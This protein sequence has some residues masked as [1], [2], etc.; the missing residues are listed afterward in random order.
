MNTYFRILKF[1]KP[2]WKHLSLSIFSTLFFSLLSGASIYLTIPLLSTLFQESKK[3]VVDTGIAGKAS[4]L[5]PGWI[6]QRM[7]DISN[8][9]N[10]FVFTGSTSDVLLKI[11]V[12]I[13]ITFL[14]KNVFGYLQAYFLAYV[15]QGVI[16]DLR[17]ST[18]RHLHKLPM[19]YF[20][21]EKTGNLISR[22][23]NDVNVVQQSV[24]AVFLNLYLPKALNCWV[25]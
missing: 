2:Y 7:N 25:N 10:G 11:C 17:N 12:L 22:I 4:S 5:A 21:N 9:F 13:L 16:R 24:A 1:V 19:S 14:L 3:H 23:T 20:K 8:W 6:T 15:E 18:Y